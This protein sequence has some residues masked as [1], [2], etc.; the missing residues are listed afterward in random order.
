[1][2]I[3]ILNG[4]YT[5]NAPDYRVS[6]PV[7]MVPVAGSTGISDGYLRPADG[8]IQNG[9]GPGIDRG[10]INWNGVC[11]RVMGTQFVRVGANGSVS[12]LGVVPAGGRVSMD[13]GFTQLAIVAGGILYYWDG[14]VLT[15]AT[16][17]LFYANGPLIDVVWIDGYFMVTDGTYVITT[18]LNDPFN[19]LPGSYAATD[20]D[21]DPI[22]ALIKLR[23]EV[24]VLN[25]NTIQVLDNTGA[26]ATGT[27]TF[28]TVDGG[29]II[30][31]T[32]GTHACCEFVEDIAFLGSGRNEAPAVYLGAN[33]GAQKISTREI[34]LV[35]STYTEAQL[36]SV[37]LEGRNDGGLQHLYVHLPDRT[38]VFDYASTKAL[39]QPTWY[40][41][42]SSTSGFSEYRGRSFVWA[43]DKW[44]VADTQ[45]E[46]VGYTSTTNGAHWGQIVR[47]EFGTFIMYN[48]GKGALFN[49]LELVALP[50]RVALG[51]NAYINTSYS[52]DGT[53][54][55]QD[56]P[57]SAGKTGDVNKRLTWFRQGHMRNWRIQRFRGDSQAHIS[58]SLL[59]AQIEPLA[60]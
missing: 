40:C 49:Q 14:S 58:F 30:K 25:R 9:T 48:E 60:Y 37:V 19:V 32:V 44:L 16:N 22:L 52:V 31:G 59:Q 42:T 4:I 23:N 1:M 47:W 55:S 26:P 18:D 5:D 39:G 36:S 8:L 10:G 11:Y 45:S 28:T 2:K 54:W 51:L 34:D 17:P 24:Y 21:P 12:N 29:K 41:L 13:Y 56:I 57:I 43:Y 20:N 53:S 6:Y 7:N 15:Q 50:G 33:A 35:L 3:P 27:F 38:F 46:A